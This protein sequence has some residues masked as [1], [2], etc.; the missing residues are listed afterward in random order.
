MAPLTVDSLPNDSPTIAN[1]LK[2]L[3]KKKPQG[4]VGFSNLPNQVHRRSVKQ[5]FYFTCMVVGESGLG[6]STLVNTLFNTAL[7]PPKQQAPLLEESPKTVEVQAISADIIENDVKLRLTVID[8]PGF[9]DYINNEDSWKP[10]L[11]NIES[12]FDAYLEQENRVN[13]SRMVDNR[14]HACMYFIAPTGHSLKPL[15]VEFMKRLHTKVNL[16]PVIAKSDT[17]TEEEIQGFKQRILADIHHHGIQIFTPSDYANDE[18]ETIAQNKEIVNK[19]PFAIVGSDKEVEVNGKMVRG[20]KY[21]WGVIEVDN[22][23][24]CD[25]SQ[26]RQMLI[27]T[28]MEELKEH[29]STIIYENYRSAK[30][31]ELGI[32]Q[33]PSVF[34]DVLTHHCFSSISPLAKMEEERKLHESRMEKMEAEMKMVFQQKVQEK[35]DKLKQTEEELYTRHKEMKEALEKQRY[36]LEQKKKKLEASERNGTLEKSRKKT[37]GFKN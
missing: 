29:T 20:R 4:Y 9:G 12:R 16:I 32:D 21:P 18:P 27:R 11:D 3:V 13:R 8:T 23:E 24:H 7:Y 34:K 36:E 1:G 30:L 6:K 28:H 26:L 25:F 35:E 15:D 14:V 10:I 33:D 31:Q 22:E 37:F 2:S 5:G 17:L 19:I